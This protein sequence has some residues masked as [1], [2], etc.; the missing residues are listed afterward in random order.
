M[1]LMLII[2]LFTA[3]LAVILY[4][5]VTAMYHTVTTSYY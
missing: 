3:I 4:V 1:D 2:I 5:M